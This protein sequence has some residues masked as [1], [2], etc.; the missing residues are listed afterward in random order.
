MRYLLELGEKCVILNYLKRQVSTMLILSLT[1]KKITE[2]E[3]N[4]VVRP[5]ETPHKSNSKNH[6]HEYYYSQNLF[7]AGTVTTPHPDLPASA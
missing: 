1:M 2:N 5:R 6:A 7:P 4:Q 3:L